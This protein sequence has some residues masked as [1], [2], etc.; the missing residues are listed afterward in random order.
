MKKLVYF[1]IFSI[2]LAGISYWLSH[3]IEFFEYDAEVGYKGEARTNFF[4][5]GE[6]FLKA[7]GQNAELLDVYQEDISELKPNDTVIMMGHRVSMGIVRSS[8]LLHWLQ[9]GGQ[10]IVTARVYSEED[11]ET[12]DYVLDKIGIRNFL[13]YQDEDQFDDMP[14]DVNINEN[15]EFLQVNLK[16][17]YNLKLVDDFSEEILWELETE[18]GIHAIAVKYGSGMI[19]VLSDMS[20]FHNNEISKYDNA[21]FL[22]GLINEKPETGKV[23]YSLLETRESIFQWLSSKAPEFLL[24]FF[25]FILLFLWAN[26]PRFGPIINIKPAIRRSFLEHI[27]A[28]GHYLVRKKMLSDMVEQSQQY[29]LNKIYSRFPYLKIENRQELLKVIETHLD[30]DRNQLDQLLY[31]SD[32]NSERSF[33]KKIKH[34]EHIRKSI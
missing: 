1:T 2:S 32:V 29:T 5:A 22:W 34:I 26:V 20:I 17:Y 6:Y 10:L 3:Y 23:Y 11:T 24:F 13:E 25:L 14:I 19:V 8:E 28:N 21:A 12:K 31:D 4:L 33:V 27:L 16:S 15:I 9:N 30:L 18:S 7:M